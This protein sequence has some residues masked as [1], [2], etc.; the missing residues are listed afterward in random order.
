MP[1]LLALARTLDALADR[2][3]KAVA[4]AVVLAIV[5]S[6][7]NALSR[8]FLGMSS[9]SWLELQWYL[10]GA[11]FM[12]CAPWTL[13]ENGHVRVDIVAGFL[14][15]RAR[16]WIELFGLLFFLLPLWATMVYLAFPYM[17][18]SYLSGAISAN[19]GGLPIWPAKAI[20]FLGFLLLGLQWL[21]E[22]IKCI[23]ILNGTYRKPE[24][25]EDGPQ[26]EPE[27]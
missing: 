4:W 15:D 19:A 7:A 23:G 24:P 10:F 5:I 26:A 21:S 14:G 1:Y 11:V 9:N 20:I 13:K 16:T 22:T 3:G 12:L 17:V 6:A 27:A 8:R 18:R 2:I 25:A